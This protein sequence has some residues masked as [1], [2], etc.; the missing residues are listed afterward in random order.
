MFNVLLCL[1]LLLTTSIVA[2]FSK[3]TNQLFGLRPN[4]CNIFLCLSLGS[5]I[6]SPTFHR[7]LLLGIIHIY[8]FCNKLI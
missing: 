1:D 3:H 5:I 7:C 2:L 4:F 8:P 6:Q